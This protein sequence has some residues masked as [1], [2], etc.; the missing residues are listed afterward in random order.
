VIALNVGSRDGIDNGTVF[1]VWHQG[2]NRMDIVAHRSRLG[3]AMDKVQMPDDYLGHV[4]V[5]RTFEKVSY[6]LVMD[7]IR[8]IRVGDVLKN[9]DATQ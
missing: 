5:F 2:A 4:M 6:G 3:Q 8:P 9:P 1:S 7:G